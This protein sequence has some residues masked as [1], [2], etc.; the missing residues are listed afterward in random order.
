MHLHV[1]ARTCTFT[2]VDTQYDSTHTTQ[3]CRNTHKHTPPLS[4]KQENSNGHPL[5]LQVVIGN[6]RGYAS[7]QGVPTVTCNTSMRSLHVL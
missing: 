5:F 4:P 7:E 3:V 6:H 2:S 1:H